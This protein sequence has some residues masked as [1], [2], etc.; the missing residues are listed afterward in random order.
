[1][2]SKIEAVKIIAASLVIGGLL[3]I[4]DVAIADRTD[5]WTASSVSVTRVDLLKLLDGG[6]AVAACATYT[7]QDGGTSGLRCTEQVNVAGAN[8]T[9]C[10]DIMNNKAPVLFK[11]SEDL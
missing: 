1:M 3:F 8:R 5:V 6:C 2:D 9:T 4:A 7:K 11:S 10:L